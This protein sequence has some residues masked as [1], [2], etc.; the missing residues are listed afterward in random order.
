[1]L[2]RTAQLQVV[3]TSPLI[4]RLLE[5]AL[6]AR[7]PEFPALALVLDWPVGFAFQAV[8][9]DAAGKSFV[10]TQNG[11]P[12]YLDDLWNLGVLGLAYRSRTLEELAELL[13]RAEMQ[14]RVQLTPAVRSPLTPAERDLL[15]LVARGLANKEIARELGIANQTVQNG[16]T[17]VF[18]KLGVEGRSEA[19]LYYWG[20]PFGPNLSS[21]S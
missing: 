19:I 8:P 7:L 1:M 3:S 16:L 12:E 18:Q 4:A 21:G 17:R 20:M 5:D 13:R 9:P 2:V 10:L 14:E 11:C 6:H 15:R